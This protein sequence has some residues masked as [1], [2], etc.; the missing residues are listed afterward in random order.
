MTLKAVLCLQGVVFCVE[1]VHA[2]NHL[3]DK[4]NLRV[5][6][7]VLVGDVI[8]AASLATRL[9]P[10]APGLQVQLLATSCQTLHALLGPTG[11][12][13]VNGCPHASSQVGGAGMDITVLGIQHEVLSRLCFDT[14]PNCLDSTSKAIKDGPNVS[15]FLHG[16]NTELI[17][18]IDPGQEGLV[19]VVEDPA[20][21]WPITLHASDLKVGVARHKEEVVVDQLLPHLL[22]HAGEREVGASK[23]ALQ[24]GKSLLHQVLDS[25]PLLLGDARRKAKAVNGATDPDPAGVHWSC[26]VDIALDLPNIH[27]AGMGRIGADS[28]VLLDQRVKDLGKVLVG[29]PV[30]SIDSTMLVIKFNSTGN[31]L[32]EGKS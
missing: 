22:V 21:L 18:L 14:V 2:I 20:P 24:V 12:V 25:N 26:G 29:V 3:L 8:G 13:N 9:S 7:P 31:S 23:V 1:C 4:L 30:S 28:M 6:Q 19:L 32:S 15:S 16:D 27:V 17:F 11:K 10:G 5:S